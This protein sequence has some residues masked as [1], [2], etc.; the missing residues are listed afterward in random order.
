MLEVGGRVI[1][2]GGRVINYISF[3]MIFAAQHKETI[4]LNV[5]QRII[6]HYK[7]PSC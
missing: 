2:V 4:I 5:L 7:S 1:E 6:L 3:A